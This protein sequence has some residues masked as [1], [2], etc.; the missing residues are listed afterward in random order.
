MVAGQSSTMR[1][2]ADMCR[3]MFSPNNIT[4]FHMVKGVQ[5]SHV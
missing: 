4:E 2:A 5:G 1:D 3:G